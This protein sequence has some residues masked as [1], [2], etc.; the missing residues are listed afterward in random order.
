MVRDT[1]AEQL[2]VAEDKS[3]SKTGQ[4][5]VKQ[6][7]SGSLRDA[8]TPAFQSNPGSPHTRMEEIATLREMTGWE[9]GLKCSIC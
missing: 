9:Q 2:S 3:P 4:E 7:A 8:L 5:G 1:V 6:K